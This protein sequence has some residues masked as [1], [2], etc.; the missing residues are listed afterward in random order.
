VTKKSRKEELTEEDLPSSFALT[1]FASSTALPG[2]AKPGMS[3]WKE[4]LHKLLRNSLAIN[5][6]TGIASLV[7]GAWGA[8]VWSRSENI[9]EVI[10]HGAGMGSLAG[11]LVFSIGYSIALLFVKVTPP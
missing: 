2:R 3:L 7:G 9:L 10:L 6:I 8:A 4:A 1:L 11:A 5:I